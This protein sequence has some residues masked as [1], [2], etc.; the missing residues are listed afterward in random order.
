MEY[1]AHCRSKFSRISVTVAVCL[2]AG[3]LAGCASKS[4]LTTGSVASFSKPLAQMNATELNNAARTAGAK[5]KSNPK[6]GPIAMQ[7]ASVLLMTGSNE[8]ALAVMQQAAIHNPED[9][10]VLAAYGKAQAG[11]GNL[12]QALQTIRRAQTPDQPNWKL[13]SA[14]GAILD[15]LG[16][17]VQA[18]Y[19]YR[20]ALDIVPD[21]PSVLSNLGMSYVLEGDLR[22]A[23]TYMRNASKQP[24]ADSRVRQNLALIVGLQGRFDEA[25]K[26]AR[27]ELS[28]NQAEANVRYLREML[29]QSNSWKKLADS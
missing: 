16:Q 5:Y 29:A 2:I 12:D 10:T 23:E 27:G 4:K 22:T 21:E 11:A 1:A 8:Q 24:A 25:E 20:E 28:G 18:R 9:R 3:T 17:S 14:E 6:S 7:Y 15:Q 13:L 19:K 26:I